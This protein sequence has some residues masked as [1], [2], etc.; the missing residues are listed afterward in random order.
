MAERVR[1]TAKRSGGAKGEAEEEVKANPETTAKGEELKG[2][3]DKAL[4]EIDGVL[5]E[6]GEEFAQK[7]VQR[8]GE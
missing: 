1:T 2:R 5:N 3:L 4:D 6:L 8:G 7:Y